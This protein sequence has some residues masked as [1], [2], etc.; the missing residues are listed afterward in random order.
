MSGNCSIED[1]EKLT[2]EDYK[3]VSNNNNLFSNRELW[4]LIMSLFWR[5]EFD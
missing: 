2:K 1:S 3:I 4:F 5:Y